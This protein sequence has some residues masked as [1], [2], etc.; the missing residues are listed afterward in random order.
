MAANNNAIIINKFIIEL[1]LEYGADIDS[2][3]KGGET[4]LMWAA[5]NNNIEIVRCLLQNGADINKQNRYGETA[6]QMARS[7]GKD[8]KK[9]VALL[10][11]NEREKSK[12]FF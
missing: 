12:P 5:R 9:I 4:C 3:D 10:L 1:L 8:N 7:N 11:Y 6:I 2:Q